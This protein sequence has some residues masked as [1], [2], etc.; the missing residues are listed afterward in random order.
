M[1]SRYDDDRGSSSSG[2][3][4]VLIVLGVIGGIVLLLALACGVGMYFVFRAASVAMTGAMQMVA[5]LSDAQFVAQG[6]VNDL[7]AGRIDQAYS[8]TSQGYQ[9]RQTKDQLKALVDKNPALKNSNAT[10]FITNQAPGATRMNAQVTA[11]GTAGSVNCTVQLIKED[12][13]WKVDGFTIP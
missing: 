4:T 10:A 2:T 1:S 8:A 9:A 13:Q 6:F 5:D 12:G 3:S 7:G 11:T